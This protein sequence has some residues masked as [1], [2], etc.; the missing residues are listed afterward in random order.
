MTNSLL[1]ITTIRFILFQALL[2]CDITKT[3]TQE[4][5]QEAIHGK[6]GVYGNY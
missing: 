2:G 5:S 4:P 6:E 1:D 3:W